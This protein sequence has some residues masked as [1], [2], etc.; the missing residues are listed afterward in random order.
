VRRCGDER[1]RT[2]R[3]LIEG[4]DGAVDLTIKLA[5]LAV[6]NDDIEKELNRAKDRQKRF[7]GLDVEHVEILPFNGRR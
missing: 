5:Y 2:W 4:E 3:S 1:F 6:H 7:C